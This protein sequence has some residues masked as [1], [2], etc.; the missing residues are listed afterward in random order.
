[1]NLSKISEVQMMNISKISD[2]KKIIN[3]SNEHQ[4]NQST[5]F[6]SDDC[7]I[8]NSQIEN[9]QI[10]FIKNSISN[11]FLFKDLSEEIM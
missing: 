10:N 7:I 6:E 3:K 2:P 8:S 11:H 9:N 5:N 1:M 4:N